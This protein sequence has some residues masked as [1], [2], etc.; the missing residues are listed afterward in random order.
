MQFRYGDTDHGNP[1]LS[2]MVETLHQT[3]Q[4]I[5]PHMITTVKSTLTS[6]QIKLLDDRM[7]YFKTEFW[8][9]NLRLPQEGFWTKQKNIQGHE[10]RSVM[11][12][13]KLSICKQFFSMT[14]FYRY[15]FA[16]PDCSI[17]IEK[18]R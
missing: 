12:V 18:N 5:F 10:Y 1:F 8:I 9:G 14:D 3:D 6:D 15:I 7:K 16:K 17:F 11:Q 4:G 2:L 13:T